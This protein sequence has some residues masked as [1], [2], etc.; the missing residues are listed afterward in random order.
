MKQVIDVDGKE[1]TVIGTA[2]VSDESRK[3]V[4]ES[5][6]EINPDLVCVELDQSRFD[7]LRDESG[8]K[9]LDVTEAIRQGKGKLLLLNLLLSIYQRKIGLEQGMKP[10]A[11]LL[12]AVNAAE[13]NDIEYS[14]VDQDISTTLSRAISS[15]SITDKLRLGISSVM[16]GGEEI[17]IEDLKTE[18]MLG[19]IIKDLEDEFPS[20]KRI[21]L[22]ERNTYMAEKILENEFD[23]AVVVVGAAH[24][25]GLIEELKKEERDTDFEDP[26]TFP[27]MKVAN[28]GFTGFIV[29]GLAFSFY[30]GLN[31]GLTNLGVWVAAN[32]VLAMI[33]AMI[34]KANPLTWMVSFVASP[35]TSL[36]P[37][38]P[39]GMVAAYSEAKIDPPTVE[40]LET[41]TE[42]ETY[43]GLWDNQ[44]GR[45]LLTFL[46]VNLGS[47]GGALISAI[48]ILLFSIL[49]L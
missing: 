16:P 36:N 49:G 21:F 18:D 38:L 2:H 45:I 33:G 17:D 4:R 26:R 20:L 12:E 13:E 47:G 30:T 41:I 34:A 48:Y 35:F 25:Q 24:V 28:Y 10:G 42:I 39:A 22:D 15:L 3:E 14:L 43:R 5:I 29:L 6:Q 1:I 32:S 37:V 27:W 40:D 9:D 44:M 23:S 46:L 7:S 19:S 11:E 31:E 8:W